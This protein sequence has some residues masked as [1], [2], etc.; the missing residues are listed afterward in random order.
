MVGGWWG[1]PCAGESSRRSLVKQQG[2]MSS[3]RKKRRGEHPQSRGEESTVNQE[4]EREPAVCG[5]KN[6]LLKHKS[7]QATSQLDSPL[8]LISFPWPPKLSMTCLCPLSVPHYRGLLLAL[9]PP[10]A[11]LHFL[12]LLEISLH[13]GSWF[14]PYLMTYTPFFTIHAI[15]CIDIHTIFYHSCCLLYYPNTYHYLKV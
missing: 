14:P 7:H 5:S 6:T 8:P 2:E 15:Y 1:R 4:L 12:I 9:T 11:L 10:S 13:G 3:P